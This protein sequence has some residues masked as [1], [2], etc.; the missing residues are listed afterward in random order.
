MNFSDRSE[1][2]LHGYLIILFSYFILGVSC[3]FATLMIV[4][5]LLF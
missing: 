3:A 4:I 5:L 1:G 2:T